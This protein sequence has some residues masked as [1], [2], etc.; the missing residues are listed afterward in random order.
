MP[1]LVKLF[2]MTQHGVSAIPVN[3][4]ARDNPAGIMQEC[5]RYANQT[6][7]PV[8]YS[9]ETLEGTWFHYVFT[10]RPFVD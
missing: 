7:K 4:E 9:N 1:A 8:R 2:A 3:A 6:R 10:P 5:Q